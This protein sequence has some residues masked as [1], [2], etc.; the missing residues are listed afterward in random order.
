[1]RGE[2]FI[3]CGGQLDRSRFKILD[4]DYEVLQHGAPG[5]KALLPGKMAVKKRARDMLTNET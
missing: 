3:G 1:M 2:R 4:N 5:R